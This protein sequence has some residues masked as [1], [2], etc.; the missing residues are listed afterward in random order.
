MDNIAAYIDHTA[1]KPEVTPRDIEK[2]CAEALQYGFASV[3]VNSSN[4]SLAKKL[5]DGSMV[6]VCTVVGFPLGA[7]STKAKCSEA[8]FAL[9]D[10]AEELDMVINIGRLKYGDHNYVRDEIA[11]LAQLAH[12]HKAILKVIIE[13]ALLTDEEKKTACILAKEA[14][15]D[16]VKTSTGFGGGGATLEDVRLMHNAVGPSLGVKASGGIKDYASAV[17]FIA[18]G[19]TRIGTSHGVAIVT[20]V[21]KIA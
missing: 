18:A 1:L 9:E 6:K 5:L 15:A 3:C 8:R 12:I 19:A 4:I 10:G 11:E 13:T 20:A 21:P 16:F 2:L 7:M 17:A 14:K